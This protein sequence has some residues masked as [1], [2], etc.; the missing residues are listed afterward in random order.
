M[1]RIGDVWDRTTE[2]VGDH[3]RVLLPLA[4]GA[5]FLPSIG[6][7]LVTALQRDAGAGIRLVLSL[8]MIALSL[9][10]L[11]GQLAVVA[12]A[13]EPALGGNARREA[14]RRFL[15]AIGV[16]SV[17]CLLVLLLFLPA[18]GMVLAS[19][20]AMQMTAEQIGQSLRASPMAGPLVLYTIAV[21]VALLFVGARMLTTTAV[22]VAE[23]RGVGAIARAWTLT[24][25][26]TWG[27]VGVLLLYMIMVGVASMAAQFV[28]GSIAGVIFSSDGALNLPL[29][30]GAGAAAAVSA[31]FSVLAGS[32]TGRL[33]AAL[34]TDAAH[35]ARAG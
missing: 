6:Q 4:I 29:L 3:L 28:V 20:V 23:R 1:V 33:Y 30:L 2:F 27:L 26:L 5:F 11:W 13:V 7:Q 21:A 9:V 35:G 31:A 14:T 34:T 12:L 15:P 19:G 32:F 10:S 25:G 22:V 16:F 18:V 24:R 17:L 8:G